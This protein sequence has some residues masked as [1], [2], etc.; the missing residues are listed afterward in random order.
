MTARFLRLTA[1]FF[2]SA[3]VLALSAASALADPQALGSFR[4][5]SVY[6]NGTGATQVC[7][8]LA[9]P[10]ASEPKKA[11]RD[12][13]FFLISDWPARKAKGEPEIVPGYPY[14]DGSAVTAQVGAD[15]VTFFTKNDGT[16]GSAWI[17]DPADEQ[18][19]ITAMRNGAQVIVT[20]T[21]RRGTLTRDTYSLAGISDAL[22]KIHS[23]CGI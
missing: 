5:W 11:R 23:A 2:L 7:Y 17:K 8:A 15:S 13:I 3:G 22:D 14:K 16:D 19:L 20:G 10:M 21:S 1:V 12:P 6:Q 4:D 9:K 18:R